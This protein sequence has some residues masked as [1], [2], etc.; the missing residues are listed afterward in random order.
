[1]SQRRDELAGRVIVVT[2]APPALLAAY[3]RGM[4]LGLPLFGDPGLALY[5]A[6]GFGRAPFAR[7]WLDPRVWT[8]YAALVAR[9]RRP[10]LPKQDTRQLGGDIVVDARQ[11]LTWRYAS[12]G[13]EDRPS[14]DALA[15][16]LQDAGGSAAPSSE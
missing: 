12:Q 10:E 15:A 4:G 8:R 11:R 1:M 3:E 7:V 2:F 14:V 9:G 16:A 5:H 6:L 13:P